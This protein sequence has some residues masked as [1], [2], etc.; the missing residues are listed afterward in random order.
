MPASG[1]GAPGGRGLSLYC[2][3]A[4]GAGAGGDRASGTVAGLRS[5]RAGQPWAGGA[6]RI[7]PRFRDGAGAA[8][9]GSSGRGD[10]V[11]DTE[12]VVEFAIGGMTCA[13]CSARLEKVLNRQPGMQAHVNLAAERARVRLAPGAEMAAVIAAVAKAGSTAGKCASSGLPWH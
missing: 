7:G 2:P 13:A 9:G 5:D 11:S 3:S 10:Q 12:R 8:A 4:R 1:A 6:L